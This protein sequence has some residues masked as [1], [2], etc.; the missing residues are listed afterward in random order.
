MPRMEFLSNYFGKSILKHNTID[1]V[2]L[3]LK[4]AS[5]RSRTNDFNVVTVLILALT[6]GEV[7]THC[8]S[9]CARQRKATFI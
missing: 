6:H 1:V 2:G 7:E 8:W 9:E 5:Q 4:A 3:M